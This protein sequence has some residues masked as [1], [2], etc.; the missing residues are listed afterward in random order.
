[1]RLIVLSSLIVGVATA[2]T[3]PVSITEFVFTPDTVTATVG[4]S[5]VWTNNGA[6]M[7]TTTS[8]AGGVPDGRWNS[9]LMASGAAFARLFDSTGVFPYFCSPHWV[10]QRMAGVIRITGSAVGENDRAA[11]PHAAMS[12]APNP[13]SG[14]TAISFNLPADRAAQILVAD[15]SGRIVR[16]LAGTAT[17]AV[18]DGRN[19]AGL[20]VRAGAYFVRLEDSAAPASARVLMID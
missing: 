7:H 12:I 11:V 1:M 18:W 14:L 15:A 20:R 16:H 13:F 4:D 6:V 19:D 8:G 10:I 3:V 2:I 5:V 9:G 17:S